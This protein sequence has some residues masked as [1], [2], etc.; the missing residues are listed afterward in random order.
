LR[1]GDKYVGISVFK[2]T[3]V[4]TCRRELK[5]RVVLKK[6]SARKGTEIASKKRD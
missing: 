2:Y 3:D 1:E 4:C 6:D 5:D